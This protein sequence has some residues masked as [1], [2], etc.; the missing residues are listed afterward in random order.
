MYRSRHL[1]P[2]P[3]GRA[4]PS[5]TGGRPVLARSRFFSPTRKDT[6]T[7]RRTRVLTAVLALAAGLLAGG[8]PALAA[9]APGPAPAANSQAADT[10]TWRWM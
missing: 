5:R 8:P 6:P 7:V 10:S 1:T 2:G 9:D 4:V 3:A